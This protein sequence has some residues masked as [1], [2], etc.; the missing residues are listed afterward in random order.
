MHLDGKLAGDRW[1]AAKS[2]SRQ[3]WKS[4][5]ITSIL[6][7]SFTLLAIRSEREQNC[8]E[9]RLIVKFVRAR[10]IIAHRPENHAWSFPIQGYLKQRCNYHDWYEQTNPYRTREWPKQIIAPNIDHLWR[11]EI[12]KR[13]TQLVQKSVSNRKRFKFGRNIR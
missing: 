10:T 1:A 12:E 5:F 8:A 3:H 9:N 6:V 2:W 7:E 13:A 11:T 4:A